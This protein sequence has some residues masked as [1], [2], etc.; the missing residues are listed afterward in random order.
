MESDG[1]SSDRELQCPISL[2]QAWR[3]SQSMRSRVDIELSRFINLDQYPH[4]PHKMQSSSRGFA[5]PGQMRRAPGPGLSSRMLLQ[6][7]N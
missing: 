7:H 4:T 5:A 1:K 2:E 3:E 6:G